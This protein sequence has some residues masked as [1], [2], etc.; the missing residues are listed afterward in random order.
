MEK[1]VARKPKSRSLDFSDFFLLQNVRRFGEACTMCVI[2][3][4]GF[5]E[6]AFAGYDDRDR[7]LMENG[8]KKKNYKPTWGILESSLI[9]MEIFIRV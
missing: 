3:C 2:R 5:E 9:C 4:L 7:C 6:I 1:K 8:I